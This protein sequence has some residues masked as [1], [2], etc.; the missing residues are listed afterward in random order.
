MTPRE[1]RSALVIF[2]LLL[3]SLAALW[4]ATQLAST[5][6]RPGALRA[7]ASGGQP[8]IGFFFNDALHLLDA[9]GA[10]VARQPLAELALTEEPTDF[11]VTVDAAGRMQAWLFEDS[12][13]RVVRCDVQAQP[14]RL[15]GCIQAMAGPQLK[16]QRAQG[17]VHIAVDAAR[18]RL[19]V[20]DAKGGGVRLL[21][22]KGRPLAA[23]PEGLLFFPN[24]VRLDGDTLLVADNDHHRLAWLDVAGE[25][26]TFQV[27]RALQIPDH[28][29]A[30]PGR[31]AADFALARGADGRAEALWLLAVAQGQKRG[32]V[33]L[34]GQDLAPAGTGDLAAYGDPLVVERFGDA[35]V[36]ADFDGLALYRIGRD[37][38]HLGPFG[39]GGLAQELAAARAQRDAA[40]SWKYGAWAGLVLTL[41]VGMLLAW[42]YG[43]RPAW[44]RAQEAVAQVPASDAF[45]PMEPVELAPARWYV[46]RL[47]VAQAVL[48]LLMVLTLGLGLLP[49]WA[50]IPQA[51]RWWMGASALGALGVSLAAAWTTWRFGRQHL[52]LAGAHVAL[53]QG[54]KDRVQAGLATVLASPRALLVGTQ[55][56]PYRTT[57]LPNRPG[58]WIFDEDLLARHL[59]QRLAPEQRVSDAELGRERMRRRPAWQWAALVLPLAAAL[60]Y[61]LWLV[62]R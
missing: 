16:L 46:Q 60:A 11:D 10:P 28:P 24:R 31:K 50:R 29:Q 38:R 42:R 45:A 7:F 56:L 44:R 6:P 17:A 39:S 61:S 20:A 26:P 36:A 33:L 23:T 49:L 30:K 34:Y 19:F 41:V 21:D 51:S 4:W 55:V 54:G 35:L 48:L 14:L 25:R 58:S 27:R 13:P 43:E 47:L 8:F 15:A 2:A 22:L 37:G 18:D 3:P 53:L 62:L 32:Q 59:L 40:R 9:G 5:L 52:R 12:T 1:R 57:R